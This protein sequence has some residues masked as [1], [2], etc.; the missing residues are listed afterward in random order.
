MKTDKLVYK[1]N[2]Y[3]TML[4][5]A[6]GESYTDDIFG[7]SVTR[8]TDAM[9]IVDTAMGTG[10][11][12]ESCGPEYSSV[13]SFNIDSTRVMIQHRTYFALYSIVN[14]VFKY[15]YDLKYDGSYV[16]ASSE[17]RWSRKNATVFFFC[18]ANKIMMYN[19]LTRTV[20]ILQEF[21]EYVRYNSKEQNGVRALGEGDLSED[22][23]YWALCGSLMDD[24]QEIFMYNLDTQVKGKVLKIKNN[25]VDNVYATPDNNIIV[26]WYAAGEARFNGVELYDK[27]MQFIRQTARSMGHQDVGRDSNGDEVLIWESAADPKPQFGNTAGTVRIR[28]ADSSQ[29]MLLDRDWSGNA[30]HIYCPGAPG[31]FLIS[32][33]MPDEKRAWVPYANEIL[34]V[35]MDG[36]EIQRLVHHRSRPVNDYTYMPK[37]NGNPDLS[38]V[39]Y[40]SNFNMQRIK[41]YPKGYSDVY[42]LGLNKIVAPP[43]P[44]SPVIIPPVESDML[45][46]FHEVD[47]RGIEG[48]EYWEHTKIINGQRVVLKM[49]E[50]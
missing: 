29:K 39:V 8:I 17:P 38:L 9:N 27:N 6:V 24:S 44:P 30:A 49:W 3:D 26:G 50:K 43:P 10:V 46:G 11:K 5:P 20:T 42:M 45:K 18:A 13:M 14:G 34:R 33:Y 1:P 47:L 40:G 7:T 21:T 37:A 4:P 23:N 12:V 15:L 32:L 25:V 41:G 28:L 36:T 16:N 31:W 22:G 2:N 35:K 19:I 48:R